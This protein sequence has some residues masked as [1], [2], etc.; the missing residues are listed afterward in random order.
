[1]CMVYIL[2]THKSNVKRLY[3]SIQN[4]DPKSNQRPS[5]LQ[6]F[7]PL[8]TETIDIHGQL[9][10]ANNLNSL[11]LILTFPIIKNHFHNFSLLQCRICGFTVQYR[12]FFKIDLYG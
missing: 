4:P 12:T 1:M 9:D 6:H 11:Y 3:A 5:E 7:I 8:L 2:H 10:I